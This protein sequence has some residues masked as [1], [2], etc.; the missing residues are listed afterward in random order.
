MTLMASILDRAIRVATAGATNSEVADMSSRLRQRMPEV[1]TLLGL[2]DTFGSGSGSSSGANGAR[3]VKATFLRWR[4]LSLLDRYAAVIPEAITASRF[5]FF[6]LMS[7][8][9]SGG[10]G[11]RL[12]SA[13]VGMIDPWEWRRDNHLVQLAMLRLL[14]RE[15]VVVI[16]AALGNSGTK[17]GG[18]QSGGRASLSGWLAERT[19][20][21]AAVAGLSSDSMTEGADEGNE[22]HAAG[23]IAAAAEENTPLGSVLRVAIAL[24]TRPAIRRAARALAGRALQSMG[25]VSVRSGGGESARRGREMA[26]VEDEAEVWLDSLTPGALGALVCL[27]K[28]A[29]VNAHAL[30]AGGIRAAAER[31]IDGGLGDWE[32]EFRCSVKMS[33][34]WYVTALLCFSAASS[35]ERVVLLFLS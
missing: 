34:L 3:D 27:V 19:H 13:A 29:F 20:V 17:V 10:E 8:S 11:T 21:T 26:A 12:A 32:V 5:D 35:A 14:A 28:S 16:P 15:G 22:G 1:Q 30:M 23:T 24:D 31:N 9:H 7:P 4:L 2:R 6:K 33:T 25:I 18:G